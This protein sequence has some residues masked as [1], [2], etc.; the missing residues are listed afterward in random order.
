MH[1]YFIIFFP[2]T[3]LYVISWCPAASVGAAQSSH[4]APAAPQ[5]C[6]WRVAQLRR[7]DS[8]GMELYFSLYMFVSWPNTI[9][10]FFK[11]IFFG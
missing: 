2:I 7:G 9:N 11:Y 10:F 3:I 1:N 5:S 4:Q 6:E 8:F